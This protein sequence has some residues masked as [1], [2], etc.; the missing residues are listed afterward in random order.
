MQPG[1]PPLTAREIGGGGGW[2]SGRPPP[3]GQPS[4][5]ALRHGRRPPRDSAAS[6]LG[7]VVALGRLARPRTARAGAR[8]RP[9]STGPG[10]LG[11]AESS[12]GSGGPY[13]RR[14]G[15]FS[16]PPPATR[17]RL[18]AS[19]T[20]VQSEAKRN[21]QL[22]PPRRSMCHLLSCR[23]SPEEQGRRRLQSTRVLSRVAATNGRGQ[24]RAQVF[25][26]RCMYSFELINVS[27]Y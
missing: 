19:G 1:G 24:A 16:R 14:E 10:P 22:P 12:R 9:A 3:P 27:A 21:R 23:F 5:I 4:R 2:P 26:S 20:T 8:R 25:I 7:C 15:S 11:S 18:T 17:S 13:W 6:S